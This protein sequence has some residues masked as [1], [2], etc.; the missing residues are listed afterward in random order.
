LTVL[1][2]TIKDL[3]KVAFD[4]REVHISGGPAW[5]ATDT[6]DINAK[7]AEPLDFAHLR[8]ALPTLLAER[9]GM[10][11]HNETR[12][13]TTYALIVKNSGS[14]LKEVKNPGLGLGL[15]KGRLNGRGAT[16]ATLL[17]PCQTYSVASFRTKPA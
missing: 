6:F 16:I 10:V 14:R 2:G 12:V 7:A 8:M 13:V 4:V 9:F 17:E 1:T 3:V 15:R 11:H 5:V